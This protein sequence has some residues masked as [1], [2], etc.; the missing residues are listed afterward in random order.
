MAASYEQSC[1][2]R[3]TSHFAVVLLLLEILRKDKCA[4]GF[5]FG[6][7]CWSCWRFLWTFRKIASLKVL[8]YARN[9]YMLFY[10]DFHLKLC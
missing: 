3:V 9:G 7:G 2:I 10:V 6:I 1:R 8:F 4:V 5:I